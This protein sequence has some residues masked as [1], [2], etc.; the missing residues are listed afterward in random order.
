MQVIKLARNKGKTTEILRLLDENPNS[1]LL[2]N[3]DGERKLILQSITNIDKH[4]EYKHR[5]YNFFKVIRGQGLRG[6]N[7]TVLIDNVDL[8]L[9]NLLHAHIKGVS[10]C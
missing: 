5:I 10:T 1:V 2:V 9:E 7:V 4:R 3:S 8:I 6:Q